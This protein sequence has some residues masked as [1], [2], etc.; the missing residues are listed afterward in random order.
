MLTTINFDT[1]RTHSKHGTPAAPDLICTLIGVKNGREVW[2]TIKKR[3]PDLLQHVVTEKIRGG[4]I[5][6]ITAKGFAILC[7]DLRTN[8][9]KGKEALQELRRQSLEIAARFWSADPTLAT[10]LIERIEDPAQLEHIAHRAQTKI[11]QRK[12]TD[13]IKEAGGKTIIYAVVNDTNNVA[14]TGCTAKQIVASRATN[15]RDVTRDLFSLEEL[16]E[17]QFI[18]LQEQRAIKRL[19]SD[20]GNDAIKIAQKEVLD[21]FKMHKK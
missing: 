19:K 8:K 14:I 5:D 13:A 1:V 7:A 15:K 3:T 16:I 10:D 12:L 11:T 21:I 20:A 2:N 6:Y 9:A 4:T 17:L 18:E